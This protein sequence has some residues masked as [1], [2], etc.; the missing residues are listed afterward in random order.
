MKTQKRILILLM[1][2]GLQALFTACANTAHGVS[3]DYRNAED[4]VE[5]ATK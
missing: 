5:N 1:A 4:H 2:L 3:A